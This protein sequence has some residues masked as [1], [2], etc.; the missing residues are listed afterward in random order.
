M[1]CKASSTAAD[2]KREN[3]AVESVGQPTVEKDNKK[4]IAQQQAA[5]SLQQVSQPSNNDG[6]NPQPIQAPRN[7]QPIDN[8]LENNQDEKDT[9]NN[10]GF[11][12]KNGMIVPAGA[13]DI[14]RE[15]ESKVLPFPY[16]VNKNN[17]NDNDKDINDVEDEK[18]EVKSNRG[19]KVDNDNN[20][21]NDNNPV[22]PMPNQ[23]NNNN[24]N[25]NVNG[26]S[27]STQ[28]DMIPFLKPQN[29]DK[30]VDEN[31]RNIQNPL[32]L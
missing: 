22:L 31:Q 29:V 1:S 32:G 18:I 15:N 5:P 30:P 3:K 11:I 10:V 17:D 12:Q 8:S 7:H 6:D 28:N 9:I 25:Y 24:N 27:S 13:N 23:I 16:L 2:Q 20:D 21:N 4:E 19:D 26:K 14:E